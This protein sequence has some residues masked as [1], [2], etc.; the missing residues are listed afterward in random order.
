MRERGELEGEIRGEK[1]KR[2]EKPEGGKGVH[3]SECWRER[4]QATVVQ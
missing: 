3:E 1:R 4:Q 2:Q